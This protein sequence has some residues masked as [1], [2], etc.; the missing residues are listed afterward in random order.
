MKLAE[1][2][3]GDAPY[4]RLVRY[5]AWQESNMLRSRPALLAGPLTRNLD[6]VTLRELNKE[7]PRDYAAI[8]ARRKRAA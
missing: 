3:S 4:W 7:A 6:P 5:A 1:H 2:P 8:A